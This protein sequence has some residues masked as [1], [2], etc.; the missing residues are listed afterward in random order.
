MDRSEPLQRRTPMPAGK[1]LE[2]RTE[3]RSR[4][5][6]TSK[7]TLPRGGRLAPR[8]AKRAGQMSEYVPLRAQYLAEHPRCEY[9]E[10]CH[11]PAV[12]VH[13]T[14]GRRGWRLLHVPWWK[15]ACREHNDAAE[16]D[17]GHC[18]DI[19]WLHRIEGTDQ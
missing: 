16:T 12:D 6:L 14:R 1:P 4:T 19:G 7:A 8:S 10:G 3:L 5:G 2:R 17:T 9:P 13:H 18:I 15:A 11:R